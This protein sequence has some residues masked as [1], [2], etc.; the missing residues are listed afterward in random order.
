MRELSRALLEPD[1]V[2]DD[3][4]TS[5]EA[6]RT[7]RRRQAA[8]TEAAALRRA[9]QERAAR[10]SG[11]PMLA[12][13][14]EME[15]ELIQARTRDGCAAKRAHG[16]RLGHPATLPA[17]I[18]ARIVREREAGRGWSAIAADLT[19]EGVPTAT[20]FPASP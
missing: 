19:A 3:A 6:T 1:V 2:A 9:R 4:P 14:A 11:T 8:A 20:C 7:Q 12:G 10:E 5:I 15:R 18:V 16:V 13:V 17:E